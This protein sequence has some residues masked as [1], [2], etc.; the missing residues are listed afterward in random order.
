MKNIF[1]LYIPTGNYEALVHYEDTIK[2]KISQEKIFQH[3]DTN[4]RNNLQKIFAQKPI[5]TWGSR[6]SDANRAKFEKMNPGDDRREYDKTTWKSRSKNNK[7]R[8]LKRVMEES[9]RRFDRR[10]GSD[11]FHCESARNRFAF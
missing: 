10:M 11:L 8:T 6:N 3:V 5:A 4:L 7:S 9:Q 2:K 1:I